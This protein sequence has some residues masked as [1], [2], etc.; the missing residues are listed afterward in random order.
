MYP[1][2]WKEMERERKEDGERE[3]RVQTLTV[4]IGNSHNEVE[5]EDEREDGVGNSHEWDFFVR[6]DRVEVIEEVQFLLVSLFLSLL[7]TLCVQKKKG[8]IY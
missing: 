3:G 1:R 7:I 6:C 2:T 8:W 4:Y 5:A